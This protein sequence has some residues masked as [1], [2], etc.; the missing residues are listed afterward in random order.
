V[1]APTYIAREQFE[2]NRL[3]CLRLYFG[4]L[5]TQAAEPRDLC[6]Q[7][8]EHSFTR[9]FSDYGLADRY[10]ANWALFQDEKAQAIP[11][12]AEARDAIS[13]ALLRLGIDLNFYLQVVQHP[14]WQPLKGRTNSALQLMAL[15]GQANANYRAPPFMTRRDAVRLAACTRRRF[16]Q[17]TQERQRSLTK[18][19]D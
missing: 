11:S 18:Y 15:R 2:G 19:S 3:H 1:P 10:Q 5:D 4:A 12:L 8:G 16:Y 13:L 9:E 17:T 14:A 6:D 7:I